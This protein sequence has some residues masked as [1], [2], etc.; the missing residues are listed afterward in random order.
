MEVFQGKTW[1]SGQ[2]LTEACVGVEDGKIHSVKKILNGDNITKI[3][4]ILLPS[5]LDMHVHF[6][7]PGYPHKEDWASGSQSA[8]FGGVTA[9]V[10]MPNTNPFTS[11][12]KRFADKVKIATSKSVVDFGVGINVELGL[13]DRSWFDTIPS[14]FWKL[15]P[16]DIT[17]EDY[18]GLAEQVLSKTKKPLVIHGEHPDFMNDKPL[19]NLADHTDNRLKAEPECLSRMPPSSYLHIAHLSTFEGFKRKPSLATSEVCPHHLLLNLDICHSINCKVD[20]PLR[21]KIDNQG[22]YKAFKE[23][24]IPILASDHAPHTVDEKESSTPPSGMPGVETMVPL[25]LNEVS[26]GRL[27]LERL[28]DAMSVQPASRLG[29][30]RGKIAEG[31][32]ADLIEVDLKD[33]TKISTD[34]L[35]SKANWTPFED[36]QAIFPSRVYRRGELIVDNGDLVLETGGQ[37]LFS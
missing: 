19:T 15:Y 12:Q 21:T 8:A 17:S 20:P 6:R 16:Y 4:G 30:D 11:D 34:I 2:G 25:M 23:G 29:L 14:A 33:K 7:D 1:V 32:P 13:V 18:F 28:V 5:A 31:Q 35:H 27:D 36:W 10:D 3:S 24:K 26:E 37:N 9:V 22:L